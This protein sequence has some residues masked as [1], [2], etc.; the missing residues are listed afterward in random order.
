M[1][2]KLAIAAMT[3]AAAMPIVTAMA[4]QSPQ[5]SSK[6]QMMQESAGMGGMM[7]GSMMSHSGMMGCPMHGMMNQQSPRIE[8]R[9]A[10]LKT[11][12][13]IKKNQEKAW[14]DYA[15]AFRSSHQSMMDRMGK[16]HGGMGK[17]GM[18]AAD[19]S[20]KTAVEALQGRIR[21][22]EGMLQS[23]KAIEEPTSKLYDALDD[24]QKATADDL[25]GMGCMG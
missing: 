19:G 21:M 2:W 23:L 12:L 15:A 11:E 4:D 14:T 24:T 3:A 22:M 16:M 5:P 10:F 8:G 17:Q 13:G 9:L 6:G 18:Q 20:G 25:L 1:N 7:G